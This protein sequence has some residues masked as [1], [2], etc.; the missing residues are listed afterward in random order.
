[1]KG[2]FLF[3]H[4]SLANVFRARFLAAIRE[5]QLV[6]PND[7]PVKWVVDCTD[8]GRGITAVQYLSRYLYRGVISEKNIVGSEDGFVTFRYVNSTSGRTE[9]RT[10]PGEDFLWLVLQHVLPRGFRR[11]RD[12]GF[13]HGNAKKL[14][15][16]IQHILRV[17]LVEIKVRPRPV[18]K[19][20]HC[21][22]AMHIVEFRFKNCGAG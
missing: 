11:V 17:I 4:K 8:V 19:C 10:V 15:S 21:K 20:P 13:L 16:L 6:L 12:Y 2:K 22:Q 14:L 3:P 9:T 1:V 18:F 5:A 7:V